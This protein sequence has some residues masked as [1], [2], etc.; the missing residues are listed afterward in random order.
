MERNK[1]GR[2]LMSVED[3]VQYES[4][5]LKQ[6]TRGSEIEIIKKAGFVIKVDSVQCSQEYRNG[7]KETE[8]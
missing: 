6:H 3:V 1:A 2:G 8:D 4:H 5:S 7:K